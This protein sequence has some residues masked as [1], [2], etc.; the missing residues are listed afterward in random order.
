MTKEKLH[1]KIT[2]K[3]IKVVLGII[4]ILLSV[5]ALI[6][7]TFASTAITYAMVFVFGNLYFVPFAFLIYIG[8]TL[9]FKPVFKKISKKVF[10]V[11]GLSFLTIALLMSLCYTIEI[12]FTNGYMDYTSLNFGNFIDIF[13]T[14]V[15]VLYNFNEPIPV[16]QANYGGGFIGYFLVASFNTIFSSH[17]G[18]ICATAAL[19]LFALIFLS[20]YPIKALVLYIKNE[21]SDNKV[22]EFK[23][24]KKAKK[25][26]ESQPVEVEEE[27]EEDIIEI[28]NH[29][30]I[31][32]IIM[33]KS[34]TNSQNLEILNQ[35]TN[36]NIP[37][38][39][40]G[41][42]KPSFAIFGSINNIM[43]EETPV[44]NEIEVVKEEPVFVK[45]PEIIEEE[46]E[47]EE[48][49][50]NN[51][52]EQES[53]YDEVSENEYIEEIVEEK[54]EESYDF[55][56]NEE[57]INNFEED[58]FEEETYEE[59][60]ESESFGHV[61]ENLLSNNFDEFEEEEIETPEPP[62]SNPTP[63][64][65][66]AAPKREIITEIPKEPTI[67]TANIIMNENSK[68]RRYK[69][70]S[71]DLLKDIKEDEEVLEENKKL[72]DERLETINCI[73]EQLKVGAK[74]T[75]YTI[76]PSVTRFDIFPNRDVS[77][78]YI[79]KYV[80]DLCSRLGG[81]LA[82]FE[83]IVQGKTSSALEI[84]NQRSMMVGYKDCFLSLPK[85]KPGVD[86]YVPF[87]KSID[88]T[89]IGANLAKF[90]HLLVSGSTGSGKSVYVNSLII[91]LLMRNSPD[92]LKFLLI[93]PKEVEFARY[94]GIPHLLG[95]VV[96]STAKAK[97][98]LD[99]LAEEMDNRY[100]FLRD[101]E[102]T[103]IKDY[104]EEAE[105]KGLPKIPSIV[106]II[107]E[108]ADLVE[109]DKSISS[110]IT[111]I[112]A[113]ARACGIHLIIATQRPSTNV[114]TGVIKSN[115]PV[116]VAFM[117]TSGVDSRVMLDQNGAES[118]VGNGDML[119][120]CQLIS[121][122]NLI[123]A[124]GFFLSSVEIKNVLSNLKENYK[125]EYDPNFTN[126]TLID[127]FAQIKTNEST[128][129]LDQ[130]KVD[131]LYPEVREYVYGLKYCSMSNIQRTFNVGF[132]RAGKLFNQLIRDGIVSAEEGLAS[133][134]K[135]VIIHSEIEY[136][137]K[138]LENEID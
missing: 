95:P 125:P 135:E 52:F 118:L 36:K 40:Q 38:D 87:G 69:A 72:N 41:F 55:E 79:E 90:P 59:E 3:H 21:T 126:L 68:Q 108:Y 122:N 56:Q 48:Y 27:I 104:N 110:P 73:F 17:I 89:N 42:M 14:Q 106:C 78:S 97:I 117:A 1:N 94:N 114:I 12:P 133:R 127:E 28:D 60:Y 51:Y 124:Q 100:S 20:Y 25:E 112:A 57:T 7:Y 138:V 43:V 34:S 67:N 45:E 113:K 66:F 120:Q 19:F 136:N 105:M 111:R 65:T 63:T 119:V 91:T 130:E 44:V 5:Y 62:V 61:S 92:D 16:F 26:P 23:K 115:I 4:L 54:V 86:L 84:P 129:Y 81:V 88:G 32:E 123:R 80:N 128:G 98:A 31:A 9:I 29:E 39:E 83:K 13:M 103:D 107:D 82:R 77:V 50:E 134:G 85:K 49:E 47:V 102:Y 18:T 121:R 99:R 96:S 132:N 10:V 58:N 35:T 74:A 2:K 93:D 53:S 131:P 24:A 101:Q 70:P 75:G 8:G 30:E 33:Q 71:P 46:P 109:N 116:R 64:A 76:G 15:D 22:K 137:D 11:L 6:N 37:T